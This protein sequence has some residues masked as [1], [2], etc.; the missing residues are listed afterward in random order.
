MFSTVSGQYDFHVGE[1]IHSYVLPKQYLVMLRLGQHNVDNMSD[2]WSVTLTGFRRKG[3]TNSHVGSQ[4]SV[5]MTQIDRISGAPELLKSATKSGN[6]IPDYRLQLEDGL[7]RE[8]GVQSSTSN[9]VEVMIESGPSERELPKQ[10]RC[11]LPLVAFAGSTGVYHIVE[12]R[13]DDV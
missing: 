3:A 2:T 7:F 6:Q 8:E 1:S 4:G 9:S 5:G 12:V 13:I 11:P 10:L